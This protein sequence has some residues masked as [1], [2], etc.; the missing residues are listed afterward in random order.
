MTSQFLPGLGLKRNR[1]CAL[2]LSY[3]Y[4]IT[5]SKFS[6]FITSAF[7]FNILSFSLLIFACPVF[8]GIPANLIIAFLSVGK[9]KATR[10]SQVSRT[11]MVSSGEPRL[12]SHSAY[13]L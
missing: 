3:N 11:P 2:P 9:K 7:V 4:Q 12:A 6:S 13:D 10:E 1:P 5:L 8:L